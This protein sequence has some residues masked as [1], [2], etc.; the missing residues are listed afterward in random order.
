MKLYHGTTSDFI[1]PDLSKGHEN[2][3]FGVGFT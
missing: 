1:V 3:D 2:T